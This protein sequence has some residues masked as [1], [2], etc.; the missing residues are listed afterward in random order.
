MKGGEDKDSDRLTLFWYVA[1]FL[2]FLDTLLPVKYINK[3][4]ALF[5]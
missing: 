1:I 5:G 3:N 2:Q 4:L